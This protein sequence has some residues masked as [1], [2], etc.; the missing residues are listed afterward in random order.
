[1]RVEAVL[2]SI[3]SGSN[4]RQL[5]L[6]APSPLMRGFGLLLQAFDYSNKLARDR[7]DFAVEIDTLRDCGLTNNDLR[8]LICG[9]YT[10]CQNEI[11]P[12][13]Q[14]KRVFERRTNS[15]NADQKSLYFSAATCFVLTDG[16][17][18][19]AEDSF[20]QESIGSIPWNVDPSGNISNYN[21]RHVNGSSRPSER[22]TP[23]WNPD[24]RE[25]S[26]RGCLVKA[27]RHPSPNQEAI[28]TAFVEDGWP[29]R[30]DDPLSPVADINPRQRLRDT[31][32]S[33]NRH[34]HN[35]LVSF[36]GDGTGEGI[37]WRYQR[38]A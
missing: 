5:L 36:H 20:H 31:I 33:L 35:A 13:G 4:P 2:Q 10:L 3:N 37:T 19:L 28:L 6:D 16:G 29:E 21:D 18:T 15:P 14:S 32:K 22:V 25:L 9:D 17:I 38:P 26:I 1:M 24:R 23:T 27:F 12:A 11:T 34:Q 30:I 7:W 8:L